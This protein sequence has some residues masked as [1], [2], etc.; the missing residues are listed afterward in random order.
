MKKFREIYNGFKNEFK[1]V[2]E[3]V[4]S[5]HV[6]IHLIKKTPPEKMPLEGVIAKKVVEEEHKKNNE[7]N[8]TLPPPTSLEIP[9]PPT[10]LEIP[11]P[12]PKSKSKALPFSGT[13]KL[14]SRDVASPTSAL[15]SI[16]ASPIGV[17]YPTWRDVS[18]K[19]REEP[20]Q[21]LSL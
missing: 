14:S 6:E 16:G 11:I 1:Q 18:G 19:M 4:T 9:M 10:S 13:Q 3:E 15:P 17:F 5:Y 8:K 20:Q 7:K 2:I 12:Q 21:K